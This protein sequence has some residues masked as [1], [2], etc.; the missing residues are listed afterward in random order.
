M[1]LTAE[2]AEE[3]EAMVDGMVAVVEVYVPMVDGMVA[4]VEAMV[5]MVMEV[6][7]AAVEVL[8]DAEEDLEQVL[9]MVAEAGEETMEPEQTE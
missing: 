4:A 1:D 2:A 9:C 8:M 5:S 3:L 7:M 6:I